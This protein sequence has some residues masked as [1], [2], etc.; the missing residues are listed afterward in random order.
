M[1]FRF[2]TQ[3][4]NYSDY[5]SGKVFYNLPGHP[6]FP[7]RLASE[8]FQRAIKLRTAKSLD[9]PVRLYDP[10]CG[11]AY[12]L[13]VLAFLHGEKI[14]EITVSDL[15][16]QALSI[17]ERNLS[18]LTVKGLEKRIAEI[19]GLELLYG[20][21]SHR[22][23]RQSADT[24]KNRLIQIN[25]NHQIPIDLFQADALQDDE[26]KEHFGQKKADLV[27]TDIPYGIQSNWI[28]FDSGLE[29]EPTWLMLENIRKVLA[30]DAIVAIASAKR[31]KI[32]H[33]GYK[34]VAKLKLGKRQVVIL[35]VE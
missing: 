10:C 8:V 16:N 9:T 13:A 1:T 29:K 33:A 21:D 6:A 22:E 35:E 17:A 34:Q 4:E 15:D 18:L 25:E 30:S 32:E 14:L 5:A 11:G 12:H 2:A 28:T 31:Q 7:I 19:E 20:K 24:L 27:I 23:A 26:I 3:R